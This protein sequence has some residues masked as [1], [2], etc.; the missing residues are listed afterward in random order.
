M[1]N[2]EIGLVPIF[3]CFKWCLFLFF[4]EIDVRFQLSFNF[5]SALINSV[6]SYLIRVIVNTWVDS[7]RHLGMR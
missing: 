6:I 1:S 4:W 2:W 7:S 5:L 3:S